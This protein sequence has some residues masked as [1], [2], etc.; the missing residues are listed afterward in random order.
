MTPP[1]GTP[2]RPT[3]AIEVPALTSEHLDAA[4]DVLA[5]GFAEEPG[6]VAL[7]PDAASRATMLQVGARLELG[8]AMPLGTVYVALVGGNVGGVAVWHP[9]GKGA[10]S[11]S[12]LSRAAPSPPDRRVADDRRRRRVAATSQ[13][14]DLPPSLTT[15]DGGVGC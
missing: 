12:G 8:R 13:A 14:G 9:P 11:L 5:R 10:G 3:T 6:M 4:V 1:R 7:L 2:A 15:S